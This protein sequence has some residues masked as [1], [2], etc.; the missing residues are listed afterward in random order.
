MNEFP[1]GVVTSCKSGAVESLTVT[2]ESLSKRLA[3]CDVG[4]KDGPGWMPVEIEPG[5]RKTERV[6]SVRLLV[7]DV[8]ARAEMIEDEKRIVGPEPLALDAMV[9]ELG[10][11]GWRCILHTSYSHT[12][13]HPRYRLAF[14]LSRPMQA[15]EVKPLGLHVAASLGIGDSIDTACLEAARLYYLPRCPPERV[16][17]FRHTETKGAALPVDELLAEAARIDEAT[18]SAAKPRETGKQ[19]ASVI[20]AFNNAH[21]V[22]AILEQFGYQ[23]RRGNRWL[24]PGSTSGAAGVHLLPDSNPQRVY[25]FHGDPLNDGHSH[26][27]FDLFRFLKHGGDISAAVRDAAHMLG[28]DRPREAPASRDASNAPQGHGGNGSTQASAYGAR[29]AESPSGPS[30]PADKTEWPELEDA[31]LYGLPGDIVRAIAPNTEADPAALLVQTLV[32]F[33]SFIGRGCHVPIEGDKHHANLYCVLVGKTAKGR[34]GTSWSR[35][36][37]LFSPLPGWVSSVSGLSSGEGLKYHVR[38]ATEGNKGKDGDPGVV[39]KRLLVIEPEFAQV[40]RTGARAGN[41][42]S[43]TVREGWDSGTLRTLT[44]ND[45]ITATGAHISII[46]HITKDE[47]RSE[48]TETESGNGFANRFLFVCVQRSQTLPFGG[49]AIAEKTVAEI[50]DRITKARNEAQ[51]YAIAKHAGAVHMTPEA[52]IIWEYVYPALS[53]GF[54]GLLGSVTAR[55]EAQVRR[56]A[57][58]YA[59]MDGARSVDVKHLEAALAL[60]RYCEQSAR[61][62]FGSAFGNRVV[63]EILRALRVAG[64]SGMTRTEIRDLFQRHESSERIGIALETIKERNLAYSEMRSTE[65]RPVEIWKVR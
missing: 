47:L 37:E 20:G 13:E 61:C 40:L 52:M 62:I 65:G 29:E 63:D 25:S 19:S 17:L 41:T 11:S 10:L 39:D 42:L 51:N 6:K 21:D 33:G 31:A 50:Q 2:L 43:A 44:K 8:E 22:G 48:L 28:M 49:G 24:W 18:K 38:D 9:A 46:S 32:A 30:K 1:I 34:K 27:A 35:V 7:F 3:R 5:Q 57:M 26:D 55:A 54:D 56:I 16:A 12:P 15:A 45:P 53:E 4:D 23:R 36:R 59:L 58:I 64:S 14:P 60:W